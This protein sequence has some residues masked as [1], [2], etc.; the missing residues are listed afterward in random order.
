MSLLDGFQPVLLC[1]GTVHEQAMAERSEAY[2]QI[3]FLEFQTIEK[4]TVAFRETEAILLKQTAA[5]YFNTVLKRIY[6]LRHFGMLNVTRRELGIGL[7]ISMLLLWLGGVIF[8]S[9]L[10]V[11]STLN[12]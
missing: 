9:L 8:K 10:I 4:I 5:I 11:N 12:F 2:S 3:S 7:R 6:F 1:R